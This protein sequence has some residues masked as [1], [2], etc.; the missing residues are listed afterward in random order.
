MDG[1]PGFPEG[2]C[3]WSKDRTIGRGSGHHAWRGDSGIGSVSALFLHW[4]ETGEK[5]SLDSYPGS[6]QCA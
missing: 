1:L 2:S 5:F 3:G 4:L 6:W